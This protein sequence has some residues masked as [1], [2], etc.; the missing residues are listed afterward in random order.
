MRQVNV[1]YDQI[2]L[3]D[4]QAR[5]PANQMNYIREQ[6]M[7]LLRDGM[8]EFCIKEAAPYDIINQSQ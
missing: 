7:L 5:K 2:G 8:Q 1:R 4:Q 3:P 6:Q